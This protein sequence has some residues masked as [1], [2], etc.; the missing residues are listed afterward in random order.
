MLYF[1]KVWKELLGG[2]EVEGGEYEGVGVL[3]FVRHKD[4]EE[5]Y[6]R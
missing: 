3:G 5:K 1:E 4:H 2:E 6:L